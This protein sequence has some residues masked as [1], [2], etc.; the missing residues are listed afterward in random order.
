MLEN[1]FFFKLK[2]DDPLLL[3]DS[4]QDLIFDDLKAGGD[5]LAAS[6]LQSVQLTVKAVSNKPN[7]SHFRC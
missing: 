4:V 3:F 7:V 1:T 5:D 6:L 2:N